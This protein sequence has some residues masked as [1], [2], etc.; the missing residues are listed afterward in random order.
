ML[1]RFRR[2]ERRRAKRRQT[3]TQPLLLWVVVFADSI[4][5]DIAGEYSSVACR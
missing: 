4:E 3:E 1:L 2:R 5:Q